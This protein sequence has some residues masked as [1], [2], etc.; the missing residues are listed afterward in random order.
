MPGNFTGTGTAWVDMLYLGSISLVAGVALWMLPSRSI[1][2]LCTPGF[3]IVGSAFLGAGILTGHRTK[4]RINR[5]VSRA[6]IR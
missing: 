3:L 1:N 6:K 2:S 4:W 5:R